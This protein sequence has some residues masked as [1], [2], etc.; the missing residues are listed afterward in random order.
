[1][2]LLILNKFSC[3]CEGARTIW[4]CASQF[5]SHSRGLVAEPDVC[6]DNFDLSYIF[7]QDIDRRYIC[8]IY[9]WTLDG[10]TR[11]CDD[12]DGNTNETRTLRSNTSDTNIFLAFNSWCHKSTFRMPSNFSAS[13]Y[14]TTMCHGGNHIR[15][16]QHNLIW[17][18]NIV[19][20]FKMFSQSVMIMIMIKLYLRQG[21]L[22]T[23]LP[24]WLGGTGGPCEDPGTIN[25]I[26]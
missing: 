3:S 21:N 13:G 23:C 25:M 14:L 6:G 9:C 12:Q 5:D 26:Q 16:H 10:R 11:C 20:R 18:Q 2:Y 7:K 19:G 24:L 15:L 1:M 17:Q 8:N 22:A 4:R